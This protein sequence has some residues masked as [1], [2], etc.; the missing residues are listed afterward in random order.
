MCQMESLRKK[1]KTNEDIFSY[2]CYPDFTDDI[3]IQYECNV[4]KNT[5]VDNGDIQVIAS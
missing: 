5:F 1:K 4:I 3:V 2:L